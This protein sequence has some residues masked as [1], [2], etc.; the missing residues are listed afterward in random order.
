MAMQENFRVQCGSQTWQKDSSD[1]VEQFQ[2]RAGPKPSGV[3]GCLGQ[4]WQATGVQAPCLVSACGEHLCRLH[5]SSLTAWPTVQCL[6][7]VSFSACLTT[8]LSMQMKFADAGLGA[9]GRRSSDQV[10]PHDPSTSLTQRS[11]SAT[12]PSTT[13]TQPS[14]SATQPLAGLSRTDLIK[15]CILACPL[16]RCSAF[17]QAHCW[18]CR[19]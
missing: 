18:L 9:Y 4:G 12:Q 15:V 5:A 3:Q 2:D 14:N 7:A 13:A 8:S 6:R 17:C 19:S 10:A 16:N 1:F 11:T